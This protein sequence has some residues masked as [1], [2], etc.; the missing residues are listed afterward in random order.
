MKLSFW[1]GRRE[2]VEGDET[3]REREE[4]KQAETGN[5]DR[6]GERGKVIS[7]ARVIASGQI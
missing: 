6:S 2:A 4:T 3:E 1:D 5:V 7:L